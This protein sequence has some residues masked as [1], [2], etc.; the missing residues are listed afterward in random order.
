MIA[1]NACPIFSLMDSFA[2]RSVGMDGSTSW[3]VMMV[4]SSMVMGVPL[5]AQSKRCT[6][7]RLEQITQQVSADMRDE[8]RQNYHVSTSS[9]LPTLQSFKSS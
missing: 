8:S 4:T 7:A 2:S 5:L 1:V 6:P 3:R 9:I